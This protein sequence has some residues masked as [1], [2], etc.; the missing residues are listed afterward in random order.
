MRL[1]N[2][3]CAMVSLVLYENGVA[4]NICNYICK[5]VLYNMYWRTVNI[6]K[7]L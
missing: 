3:A 6:R 2:I 1:K 7:Y 4:Y 5:M